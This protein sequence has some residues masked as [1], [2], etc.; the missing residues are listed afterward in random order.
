MKVKRKTEEYENV[1]ASNRELFQWIIKKTATL[2]FFHTHN[3]SST[4][5]KLVVPPGVFE[6]SQTIIVLWLI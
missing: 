1:N 2:N 3:I 5:Y 6:E 4:T